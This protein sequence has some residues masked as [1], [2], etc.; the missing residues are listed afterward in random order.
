V[1]IRFSDTAQ[2]KNRAP[3]TRVLAAIRYFPFPAILALLSLRLQDKLIVDILFDFFSTLV[4]TVPLE[5]FPT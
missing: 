2:I 3:V 5:V 1:F 4:F